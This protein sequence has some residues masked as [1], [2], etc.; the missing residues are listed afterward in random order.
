MN[1]RLKQKCLFVSIAMHATLVLIVVVASAFKHNAKDPVVKPMKVYSAAALNQI[2]SAP[3][4]AAP[5]PAISEPTPT[6][7][8][9]EPPKPKPE[10]QPT[11][12]PEPKKPEPPKPQKKPEPKKQPPKKPAK[13]KTQPR[14]TPTKTT[15]RK[16]QPP[17]SP[18]KKPRQAPTVKVAPLN[19]LV[20]RTDPAA[21]RRERERREQQRQAEAQRMAKLASAIN[22][23]TSLKP[24]RSVAVKSS[25]SSALAASDYRSYVQD[26]YDRH[27]REPSGLASGIMATITVTIRR[28]G[29]V[30]SVRISKRSGV[31]R[32]DSSVQSLIDKVRK[33]KPFPSGMN[34]SEKTFTFGFRIRKR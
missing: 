21:E 25:G 16:K 1:R 27:W 23:A 33:F 26:T 3:A 2:L 4:T 34:D 5:S 9:V 12:K 29:S 18:A 22:S 15:V 20:T 19:K 24:T 17:K 8:K 28:D 32:L 14:K 31:S 13:P 6:P 7:P 30:K 10:P 11:P